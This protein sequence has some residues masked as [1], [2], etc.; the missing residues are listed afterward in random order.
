MM[1]EQ[2][3]AQN[4]CGK[5]LSEG[6]NSSQLFPFICNTCCSSEILLVM[7]EGWHCER[8]VTANVRL[9]GIQKFITLFSFIMFIAHSLS[10]RQELQ[11][12]PGPLP[13]FHS[14]AISNHNTFVIALLMS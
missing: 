7:S 10:D 4:S 9:A 13:S 3:N 6:I 5:N 1:I 2:L 14:Q 8:V 12:G 11:G